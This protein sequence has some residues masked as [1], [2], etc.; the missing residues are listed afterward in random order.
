M[1]LSRKEVQD[2]L[3][4]AHTLISTKGD[5]K[6][7][8]KLLEDTLKEL[9]ESSEEYYELVLDLSRL[10]RHH[11]S[12][13]EAQDILK[14]VI[15]KAKNFDKDIYLADMYRSLSFIKLHQREFSEARKTAK[16]GLSIVKYMRGFKAE[17]TKANIYATLGNIY[18]TTKDYDEALENY[19]KAL[20]K[21]EDIEY[22][23][24]EISVKNDMA[25]V[26]IE[27]D[28]LNKAKDLLLSIKKDAE[29]SYKHAIPS[30][31]LRLA[32]IEYL[33]ANVDRSKE[34]IEES[35]SFSNKMGWKNDMAEAKEALARI[36]A[37]EGK[38]RNKKS[39]LKKAYKIYK[40]I[41]LKKKAE[42][43]QKR[44]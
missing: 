2:T 5:Y 9:E 4:E 15:P 44:L 29:N 19:K 32:R 17:K 40:K 28:K 10:Y 42:K 25:N 26:Y 20:K 36:Y 39:E 43:I 6:K 37:K 18:F 34:Y 3:E 24:R 1:K 13:T 30:I 31:L 11:K 14:E 12:Y 38:K 7:G 8:I 27:Q 41:G 21:S 35:I 16:K 22:K 33:E 23:P